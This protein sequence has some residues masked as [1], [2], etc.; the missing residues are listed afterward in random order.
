MLFKF[1][2]PY[3]P[4][5]YKILG[6]YVCIYYIIYSMK[7]MNIIF[8]CGSYVHDNFNDVLCKFFEIFFV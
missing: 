4:E 8:V 6:F 7:I 2:V 1:E 5:F 3:I